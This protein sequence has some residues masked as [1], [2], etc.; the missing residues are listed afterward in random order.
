VLGLPTV[1]DVGGDD[2][3]ITV[4]PGEDPVIFGKG[5]D[6]QGVKSVRLTGSYTLSCR[7]GDL[8]QNKPMTVDVVQEESTPAP[9]VPTER[10]VQFPI[11]PERLDDGCT[12]GYVLAGFAGS[13]VVTVENYGH[14]T[15]RSATL[16]FRYQRGPRAVTVAT[17]NILG[18]GN[19]SLGVGPFR[20]RLAGL[21]AAL[22]GA[23]VVFLQEVWWGEP[24]VDQPAELA[25]GLGLP[26]VAVGRHKDGTP[27]DVAILSRYPLSAVTSHHPP[28]EGCVLGINCPKHR[29]VLVDA[30]ANANGL[31]VRLLDT[32]WQPNSEDWRRAAAPFMANI[33][34]AA[35]TPVVFG[36]DLNA[37]RGSVEINGILAPPLSD[38]LAGQAACLEP[39]DAALAPI[40]YLLFTAPFAATAQTCLISDPP[41]TTISLTDHPLV[42]VTFA[43]P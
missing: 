12:G 13:V 39:P 43:L 30:M 15:T 8:G 14:G 31:R 17:Y 33:V 4:H 26:Y 24:G 25:A 3:D 27:A 42:R 2:V 21:V 37:L 23:D 19:P 20:D 41:Q 28:E 40:D 10:L 9:Q 5:V 18:A 16:N 6:P 32:H 36:G 22:K 38:A 29:V 1:I 35:D 7:K 11:G 34:K